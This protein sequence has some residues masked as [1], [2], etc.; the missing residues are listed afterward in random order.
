MYVYILRCRD[1][2]L[3]TGIARDPLAR[4]KVHNS[5][6]GAKY[7]RARRPCSLVYKEKHPDLS[8]SLK[9]ERQIKKLSRAQ[10]LS[11]IKRTNNGS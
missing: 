6:K 1:S 11:L 3:Y 2:T 8:A 9:R 4:L 10:K 5:G 7:T